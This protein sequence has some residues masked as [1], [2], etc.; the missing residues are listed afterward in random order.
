MLKLVALSLRV[1]DTIPR[2]QDFSKGK[3]EV[4]P[5]FFTIGFGKLVV[6]EKVDSIE[7]KFLR[8][9]RTHHCLQMVISSLFRKEREDETVF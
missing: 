8:L 3:R 6:K 7:R 4:V 5:I 1:G 2:F 9:I